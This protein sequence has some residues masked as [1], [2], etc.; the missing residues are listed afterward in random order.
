MTFPSS[1]RRLAP[2]SR[3][4]GHAGSSRPAARPRLE[5]L[6][7]RTVPTAVAPP[8]GLVSW[9]TGDNTAAD[10]TTAHHG[11]LGGGT[12]YASGKVGQAFSFDGVD[13]NVQLGNWFNL[14]SFTLVMWVKPA[15]R[16]T[17][18][19]DII[20]N[21]HRYAENWVIQQVQ[22]TTN[23]YEF[24]TSDNGGS[25]SSWFNLAAN[26]WQLLAVSKD[27]ASGTKSV[28]VDGT[29][30]ESVTVP[31]SIYYNGSQF[32]RLAQWGAVGVTG[33][34]CWMKSASSTVP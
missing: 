23:R 30:V 12:T 11:T 21:N 15:A 2:S 13:D 3:R 31:G 32:L 9:W 5:A 24:G 33:R 17:T 7:D 34:G 26:T 6:E 20:D 28:Y 27:E 8:A 19:A 29:L 25:N 14:Q 1:L 4:A 18:Y 22:G 16:Q 10:L